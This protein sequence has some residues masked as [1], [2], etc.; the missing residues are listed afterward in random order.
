MHITGTEISYLYICHR[1]LW[2]FHHGIRMESENSHVQIGKLIQEDSFSRH[3]KEIPIGDI[4]VIDWAEFKRGVIHETKKA[5][6]PKD[7]EIAQ[8]RY[9]LWWLREHNVKVNCCVIHYPRQKKTKTLEWDE[10][11]SAQVREDL[12]NAKEIISMEMPPEPVRSP[13]CSSCAYEEYCFI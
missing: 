5:K 12:K 9:Y 2:L 10:S 1:K 4:G 8:T 7:A 13:W 11:M 3:P 6:C